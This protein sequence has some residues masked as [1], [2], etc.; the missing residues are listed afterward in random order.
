M[1]QEVA[2]GVQ[3]AATQEQ[4][5]DANEGREAMQAAYD[6]VANPDK[7]AP[8]E[9]EKPEETAEEQPT[10]P[11]APPEMVLS[12]DKVQE[13]LTQVS[14]I[15]DLEKQLRDAGGRYGALKQ[16]I[17][18]LQQRIATATTAS[19]AAA[20]TA[21]AGELLADL[22][23]E[24]PEL[25]DKLQGAFSRVMAAKGGTNADPDAVMKAVA[26][27]RE[28][29]RAAETQTLESQLDELHPGWE[30][31]AGSRGRNIQGSPEFTDWIN[32]LTPREAKRLDSSRDPYFIADM[33]DKHKEW[34]A[35]R[36]QSPQQP[37]KQE[38]P[39]QANKSRLTNAVTPT[40]GTRQTVKGEPDPKAI[41]QAAYERVAGKRL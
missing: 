10:A 21:D 4:V 38:Q 6:R 13:L 12:G 40:N 41:R 30:K 35:S 24:F 29:E 19:E 34:L 25:A 2:D 8:V 9:P 3:E 26:E 15:P 39:S 22:R 28:A 1:S 37:P 18:Q 36:H 23:D 33:L 11:S 17:E 5:V 20:N 27:I 14:R 31:I 16:S 7:A 32:T